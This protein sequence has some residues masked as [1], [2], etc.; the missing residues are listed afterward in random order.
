MM[1]NNFGGNI[2]SVWFYRSYIFTGALI[3]LMAGQ[4][5][6]QLPSNVQEQVN[7]LI[8]KPVQKTPNVSSMEKYGDYGV[9]L[10]HGLPEISIPLFEVASG[11]LKL[12]ISLSYHAS[13]IKYTDQA[14]WAG[15]GWTLNAGGMITRSVQG[16]RDETGG[17]NSGY[18]NASND[19]TVTSPNCN[20]ISYKESL[21]LGSSDRQPDLFSYTFPGKSGKFYLSQNGEPPYLFPEAPIQI[22][23]NGINFFD[24][25]DENGIRYRFGRS[26]GGVNAIESTYSQG[27]GS[28][29]TAWSAWYL[30]EIH[31]PDTDDLIQITYQTVGTVVLG[32][33]EWN[34]T[35]LDQ[36]Y[37]DNQTD[38]P[39]PP[40]NPAVTQVQTTS[41]TTQ[42]GVHEI[43][44]KTGKIKFVLGSNRTDLPF[45][46]AVKKLDRIEIYRKDGT[47]YL[48][49]KTYQL[50]TSYFNQNL[51]LKLDGITVRD[52]A[53]TLV[54]NYTFTYHTNS[55]SWNAPNYSNRRDWFGFYNGRPNTN[56]I[57]VTTIP[58]QPNT[59]TAVSN[60]SIGGANREPDTTFLK[61]GVIRRITFPTGGYS[62]FDFEPHRYTDGGQ[63]KYGGGLRIKRIKSVT[64][65]S[66]VMKEYRYGTG[67][68]GL[69]IKNFEM[70]GF[71]FQHTQLVRN[72]C[73]TIPC[74]QELRSR[75]FFSNSVLG[76]GYEDSPVVY[77][78]VSEYEN[79]SSVN[80]R[81][82]YV[83]D[84]NTHIGDPLFTVPYSNKTFRNSM[85]WARG[86]LTQK[87][88]YNSSG[89]L[90]SRTDISYSLLKG[91]T[92]NVGQ[93]GAQY[94]TGTWL[95]PLLSN[96][97][98]GG[99]PFDGFTYHILNLPKTTG[100]YLENNRTETLYSST[101]NHLTS[102]IKQY[103][104]NYLQLIHDEVRVSGNPEAVVTKY[105][106]PFNL[107]N[108]ST[109]YT[110]TPNVL[111]QMVLKNMLTNPVEQYVI[112]Q[113]ANGSNP[114]VV[115]GQITTF[116]DIGSARYK[117]DSVFMVEITAPIA[118]SG[119]TLTSGPAISS[120]ILKDSRYKY[121]LRFAVYDNRGNLSQVSRPNAA[122]VAYIWSYEGAYAV[123]EFPNAAASQVA[124][125]S[126]ETGE[127]GGWSYTGTETRMSPG[128]AKTGRNVYNLSSGNISRNVSGASTANRFKVSFWARTQSGTQSWTFMGTAE[129]LN[130][131][132]KLIEREVTSS[133]FSM[134]GSDVLVDEL[135]IA[136]LNSM[137]V[138]YTYTPLV[139]L[140]SA[141]DPKGR[142]EYYHYDH[143]GRL[144]STFTEEGYISSHFEYTFKK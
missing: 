77:P 115:S 132:W 78:T 8:P 107:V 25:T 41:S 123:G 121:R 2:L 122:S 85:S 3:L 103:D 19:Y 33:H 30:M 11:T 52:G 134:S 75:M 9:N 141:L 96:C 37:T 135:R 143:F 117:A 63:T 111:K 34:T 56:L 24:I 97:T 70:N 68:N 72:S 49:H 32:D 81:T 57:P 101:G 15:L 95:G 128:E 64:G 6:A 16:N 59:N 108:T 106:Y 114:R 79:G 27:G 82:V 20:N 10:Y 129:S 23:R 61:E 39:C 131:S 66:Q 124:Y 47:G 136:P 110:G 69:G 65:T 76:P 90:V 14:S 130:T 55:F 93:A 87:S 98:Y 31:S 116:R 48:L 100:I 142:G 60:I 67:E 50:N 35:V 92:K 21:A 12:P 84:G 127:K 58:Y 120:W 88:A 54:N 102:H 109:S 125:T 40:L 4:S 28:T 51:R 126:F 17:T 89:S 44:F 86:K 5:Y 113:N 91:Q 45:S 94:I 118:L 144:L 133:S 137:P 13:G 29:S 36:C 71:F 119:F 74:N 53:N 43:I 38:L 112:I 140:T 22:T 104:S 18:L 62:E 26:S 83:F 99:L 7:K 46:T 80:G 73:G 138:T 1:W 105:R 139:G 42:L